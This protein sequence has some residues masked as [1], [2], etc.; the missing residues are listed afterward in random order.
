[1]GGWA[2]LNGKGR[3]VIVAFHDFWQGDA[4]S[5][6]LFGDGQIQI[7]IHLRPT[8]TLPVISTEEDRWATTSFTY[9]LFSKPIENAEAEAR[10]IVGGVSVQCPSDYYSSCGVKMPA[11]GK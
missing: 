11:E 7:G 10:S 3:G 2:A 8:V 5:I 4:K 9:A 6:T 1:M